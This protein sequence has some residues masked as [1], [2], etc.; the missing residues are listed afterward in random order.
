MSN[1]NDESSNAKRLAEL[2]QELY[3]KTD[4]GEWTLREHAGFIEWDSAVIGLLQSDELERY[5][6]P[7]RPHLEKIPEC[8]SGAPYARLF[9]LTKILWARK[10]LEKYM[11]DIGY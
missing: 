3:E 6:K 10:G 8:V 4:N 9:H 7:L 1:T 5:N 2:H 11:S